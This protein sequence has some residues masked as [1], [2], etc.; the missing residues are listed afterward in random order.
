METKQATY[1]TL[2]A[3]DRVSFY[4]WRGKTRIQIDETKTVQLEIN[5]VDTDEILRAVAY[6]VRNVA[7]DSD[8]TETQTRILTDIVTSLQDVLKVKEEV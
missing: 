1:V 5:D 6:F 3:T 2:A 7:G 4:S 8:R